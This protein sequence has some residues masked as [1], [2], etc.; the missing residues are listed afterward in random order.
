MLEDIIWIFISRD[1][2]SGNHSGWHGSGL[3]TLPGKYSRC[4]RGENHMLNAQMVVLIFPALFFFASPSGRGRHVVAGEG[5]RY[6]RYHISLIPG[7]SPGGRRG[8]LVRS[9]ANG[10]HLQ[11]R[12]YSHNPGRITP[13][14]QQVHQSI[15]RTAKH[16]A[17]ASWMRVK[18][19]CVRKI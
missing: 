11:E 12:I 9:V 17:D 10:E 1:H 15:F 8:R 16:V 7:P 19:A 5:V 4:G 2:N 6:C 18:T 13:A 14:P 3:M